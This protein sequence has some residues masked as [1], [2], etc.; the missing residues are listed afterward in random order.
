MERIKTELIKFNAK[1]IEDLIKK[2]LKVVEKI[3]FRTGQFEIVWQNDWIKGQNQVTIVEV[4]SKHAVA[5]GPLN[6]GR[7]LNDD[8]NEM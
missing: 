8:R 3:D 7:P 1:D 2:H 6:D 5:T 4:V